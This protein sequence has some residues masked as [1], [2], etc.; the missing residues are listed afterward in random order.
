MSIAVP[1]K[2]QTEQRRSIHKPKED[3]RCPLW[4]GSSVESSSSALNSVAE[5]PL[6]TLSSYSRSSQVDNLYEAEDYRIWMKARYEE[7]KRSQPHF[8]YR[9]MALKIGMDAGQLVKVLQGKLHL[10]S[11]KVPAVAKLFGLDPRSEKF[12]EAL[13][14]FGKANGPEEIERRWEELQ[15]LRDIH[16]QELEADQYEFYASW[17]PTA[18]RGLL[19]LA[20]ADQTAQHLRKRLFPHP[21]PMAVEHT[22]ELLER[23]QLIRRED[24]GI[25]HLCQKHIRTGQ[26]WRERTVREF[27]TDTM[28]LATEALERIPPG[29]RD[30][31]TMTLTLAER[32]LPLLRERVAEFRRDLVRLAE[33][34]DPADSVFQVNLQVFPLTE[35]PVR[36]ARR[37]GASQ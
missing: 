34:S 26:Q 15:S 31:S 29:R 19:S 35:A 5:N 22:L 18:V 27:Q 16:A 4:S 28:R 33:E 8:S 9:Y 6:Q 23:L 36:G 1:A 12:F 13:V 11:S 20:E 24:D 3:G 17:L 37:A 21:E 30:I 2:A 10:V 14:L 32:D 25:W 7:R